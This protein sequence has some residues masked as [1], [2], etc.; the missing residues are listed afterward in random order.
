L[1]GSAVGAVVGGAGGT[2]L[3]SPT[4]PGAIAV[5]GAGAYAGAVEGAVI[6]ATIGGLIGAGIDALASHVAGTNSSTATTVDA[7]NDEK[8]VQDLYRAVSPAELNSIKSTQQFS[9]VPGSM[10][11]KQFANNLNEAKAFRDAVDPASHIVGVTVD[12]NALDAIA[13]TTQVDSFMFPS[14]VVTIDSMNI[15]A[16]NNAII[17]T[18]EQV[19]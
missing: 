11:A 19:E 3:G 10:E 4:G 18:I 12:K 14:G 1:I 2:A 13:D 8:E 15:D 7:K 6:G 5:G 16:F 9:T 17:G